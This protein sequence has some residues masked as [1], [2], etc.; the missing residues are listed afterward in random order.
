MVTGANVGLGYWTVQHLAAKGASVVM[1]CRSLDKCQEAAAAI[2]Q[3]V[4]HAIIETL[5]CDLTS[6]ASIRTF[7]NSFL[8]AHASLHSLVLNAGIMM[9]PFGL[10]KDGIEQQIGVNHFGHFLLSQL[11]LPRLEQ[12]AKTAGH[13]TTVS[14]V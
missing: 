10:T 14:V 8:R 2:K 11:L 6:F 4:P 9:T 13:P 1:G 3:T 12:T 5:E 7:A